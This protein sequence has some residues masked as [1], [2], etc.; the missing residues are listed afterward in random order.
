MLKISNYQQNT[1][2]YVNQHNIMYNNINQIY[3]SNKLYYII[4]NFNSNKNLNKFINKILLHFYCNRMNQDFINLLNYK[5]SKINIKKIITQTCNNF[6]TYYILYEDCH[7]DFCNK[8]DT[9]YNS[10]LKELLL[11][12][13]ENF[14]RSPLQYLIS[15][16]NY[17]IIDFIKN[18]NDLIFNIQ[19]LD[20]KNMNIFEIVKGQSS[21]IITDYKKNIIINKL[22]QIKLF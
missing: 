19:E 10:D 8:L 3:N 22:N 18:K 2:E 4:E 13:C 7:L 6:L 21:I 16:G 20:N 14:G 5:S 17:Q 11:Y 9:I 1:L 12:K 15:F